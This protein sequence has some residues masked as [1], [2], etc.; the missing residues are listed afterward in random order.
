MYKPH[1]YIR[2]YSKLDKADS[3]NRVVVSLMVFP[4]RLDKIKPIISSLLDQTVK[5]DE[6]SINLPYKDMKKVPAYLKDIVKIYGHSVDYKD[7]SALIPVLL[8]ERDKNTKIIILKDD[9]IYGK[10]FI[11][12][13]VEESNKNPFKPIVVNKNFTNGI[14]I[15]S[16]FFDTSVCNYDDKSDYSTWLNKKLL[17]NTKNLKYN[18]NYSCL[19]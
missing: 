4:D 9:K 6:I 10:D 16:N 15:K 13:L 12:T 3:K 18:E 1:S 7:V 5:I 8:R 11:E 14:L 19:N 17:K 2:N